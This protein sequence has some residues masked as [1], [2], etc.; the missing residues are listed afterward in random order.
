MQVAFAKAFYSERRSTERDWAKTE[1]S[2]RPAA[3]GTL[4]YSGFSSSLL[5]LSCSASLAQVCAIS[6]SR[7][8]LVLSV[9]SRA[10]PQIRPARRDRRHLC[11]S[12]HAFARRNPAQSHLCDAARGAG[13]PCRLGS[14]HDGCSDQPS[15]D[16]I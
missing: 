2:K 6:I 16:Q 3:V 14:Q 4:G 1:R 13:F 10:K 11:V 8:L 7:A 5:A 12:V 9:A 15:R